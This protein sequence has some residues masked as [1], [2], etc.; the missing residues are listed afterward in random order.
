VLAE[1]GTD[2][3]DATALVNATEAL[4]ERR[5]SSISRTAPAFSAVLRAYRRALLAD[6]SALAEGLIAWIGG[7]HCP[8]EA[9]S[10]VGRQDSGDGHPGRRHPPAGNRQL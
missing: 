7:H 9:A 4:M 1:G 3:A 10:P 8:Q 2:A 6:Q 5:L